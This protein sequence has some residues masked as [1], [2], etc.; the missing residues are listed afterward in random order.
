MDTTL[1]RDSATP[2]L[3]P[4]I[5]RS[6][7][8]RDWHRALADRLVSLPLFWK[9]LTAN[10]LLVLLGV[11]LGTWFTLNFVEGPNGRV[12]WAAI[13]VMGVVAFAGSVVMNA[14]VLSLALQPLYAL[15]RTVDEVA[16][17]NLNAR[18]QR[19]LFNDP[20]I[21]RLGETLNLMLDVLREHRE[22][23]QKRSEQVLTAQE[24]ERKRIAR[25]LHDE[26]AQALTTLL[27]R[28]KMLERIREP[29]A[30][31]EQIGEIRALTVE[32]LE[33]V[34][35]LAVDL[36][37]ST[38]DNLGL[39]AALEGYVEAYQARLPVGVQFESTGFS[40]DDRRLAAQVELVLYRVVQEALT[41]VAKHAR[42][43]KVCVRLE[44]TPVSVR[45]MVLDDGVG[46]APDEAMRSPE[47]GLGLFGMQERLALVGGRL[48]IQSWPGGGTRIEADVPLQET[49]FPRASA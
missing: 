35:K 32:T 23:L 47:R 21:D 13:V 5:R 16:G 42:A 36:R 38:L 28:L 31:K 3:A 46:F 30:L 20:D 8:V 14:F 15:E 39:L 43:R 17:G 37:P 6:A 49:P 44:R 34:R 40:G 9:V 48:S 7:R 45:A 19:V 18:A 33:A 25:E 10:V 1:P 22:Q 41:N 26:T 2:R 24:D 4:V 12:Q 11:W 27:I 29:E